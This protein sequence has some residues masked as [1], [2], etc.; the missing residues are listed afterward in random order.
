MAEEKLTPDQRVA[1]LKQVDSMLVHQAFKNS[2]RCT[3]LLRY[4]VEQAIDNPSVHIKER[5]LGIEVFGRDASYDTA[6]DPIVR[7]TASEIRKRIAQYYH[8]VSHESELRIELSVGT[9]MPDFRFIQAPPPPVIPQEA[10]PENHTEEV[11]PRPELEQPS[12]PWRRTPW[13]ALGVIAVIAAIIL[14]GVAYRYWNTPTTNY[15]RFWYPLTSSPNRVLI[16]LGQANPPSSATPGSYQKDIEPASSATSETTQSRQQLPLNDVNALSKVIRVLETT[17]KIYEL[18]STETIKLAD[19]RAGPV[20]LIGAF[21][22]GW[23]MKLL[24]PLRFHFEEDLKANVIRIRDTYHP[25]K[26]DWIAQ[27]DQVDNQ[28]KTDYAL[29]SRYSD[30]LTGSPV[31]EIAGLESLGTNAAAEFV[32][33]PHF[34]N[35]MGE[36]MWNCK[37]NLQVVLEVQIM[38][39]TSGPP[40]VV[41]MHC[42]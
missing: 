20:V 2:K 21:D 23:T 29:V 36:N 7:M 31:L 10:A 19:L 39:G 11:H 1:I 4:L 13:L 8:E 42:W 40:Q 34:L 38:D 26:T 30:E 17:H 12:R 22:N 6:L 32:S 3:A 27:K 35:G 28:V 37:R 5:T 33:N 18:R 24:A 41:A 25:E 16:C 9:Y 15:A 14:A